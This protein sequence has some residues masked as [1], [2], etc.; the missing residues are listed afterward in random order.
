MGLF[1]AKSFEYSF[2]YAL[3]NSVRWRYY[4]LCHF[5]DKKTKVGG[6]K[7]LAKFMKV[8]EQGFPLES[9][10]LQN[11]NLFSIML[12]GENPRG[13]FFFFFWPGLKS[14]VK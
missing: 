1:G 4:L 3:Q 12:F 13:I 10:Q 11:L 2:F 6:V 5:T 9:L 7:L 14:N 8:V